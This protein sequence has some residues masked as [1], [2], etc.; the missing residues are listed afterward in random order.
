[1]PNPPRRLRAIRT[2][3][4]LM[5][6]V[7]VI[8][9]AQAALAPFMHS[10]VTDFDISLEL[11]F[12]SQPYVLQQLNHQL[13]PTSL[14][15]FVEQ[16]SPPQILLGLF[17]HGL[18]YYVATLPMIIFA[19]RLVDQ[20]I[21]TNPFTTSMARGLRRLGRI[22]L[23]GGLI[24]ELI[25]VGAVVALYD[26]AVAGGHAV[27][28]NAAMISAIGLWWLPMGLVILAFAQVIDHGCALRAE[29]DEVI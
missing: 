2:L 25:R 15:V 6:T 20:A 11:V 4:T 12:G 16:A 1:M 8:A 29:L 28:D 23:A 24:A 10:T 13:M 21:A 14:H 7:N 27:T 17:A 18:A 19:R 5:L 3:L 26:S 22:V 9:L